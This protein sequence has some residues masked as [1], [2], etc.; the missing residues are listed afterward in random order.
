MLSDEVFEE[1]KKFFRQYRHYH[2]HI[3]RLE[4]RLYDLDRKLETIHAVKLTGLPKG[5]LPRDL[6]DSLQQREELEQRI[7]KLVVESKPIKDKIL[8]VIDHLED[9]VEGQVLEM[10][11]I[12]DIQLDS[13]AKQLH[14]SIRQ[15]KRLYGNGVRNATINE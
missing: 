15:I 8:D 6:S 10:Y 2:R 4:N 9:D 1:H 5:G 12:E 3:E 13:V 14:Y 7:N 11:F